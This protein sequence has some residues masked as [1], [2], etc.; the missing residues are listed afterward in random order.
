M[1]RHL[2]CCWA[3]VVA[4]IAMVLPLS[5]SRHLCSPGLFA[6]IVIILL[7][8]S[9]WCHC[10]CQAGVVALVTMTL[11]P[12]SIHR[13]LHRCHNGT[14]ALLRWGHCQHCT[15]IVALVVP[16]LLSLL[17]W[18]LCPHVAWAS[19]PLLHRHCC[20]RWAGVFAPLH[21]CHC[22]CHAGIAVLGAL[23]LAPLLHRPLYLCCACVMQSIFRCLCPR[24][25]G[26]Y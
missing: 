18:P 19:S 21:W 13:Y 1:R 25:A 15:S 26:I 16:A 4:L 14:V 12:P 11:S 17:R 3:G 9:W 5:M 20:P 2:C 23:A 10:H 22:L 8:L 6:V 24:W 7:S